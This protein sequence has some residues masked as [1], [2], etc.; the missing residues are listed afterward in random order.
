MGD[1][2]SCHPAARSAMN[3]LKAEE[4]VCRV[5]E[6]CVVVFFRGK[7]A[8]FITSLSDFLENSIGGDD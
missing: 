3:K 4:Q 5:T 2:L 1:G 8:Q 6:S 7:E